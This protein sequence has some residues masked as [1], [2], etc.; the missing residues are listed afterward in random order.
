MSLALIQESAKEVRRLAI[1]GSPLAIGDFRLKKLVAPLEQAGAK[2]P[3]FAQV[4]RSIR[5]LIE[6]K[7]ADSAA[8]LLSL[9]TLLNA[10]LY[11]QGQTGTPAA[12]EELQTHAPST[13][14]NSVSTRTS[15]RVLRPIIEALTS[16]GSG[17]FEVVRTAVERGAFTD[18]RLIEPAL[19]ALGDVY[20]ELADLVAEKILPGYGAGIGA[21]VKQNFQIKGKKSDARRLLVLH[22]I[23]RPAGLALA[24]TALEEGSAE[25][26]E[27]AIACLG[28]HEDCLPLVLEQATTSKNKTLRAAALAALADYDRPETTK[29]FTE[30]V[31]GKTLELL[32]QP[33]RRIRNP[34]VLAAL[35]TEGR[36]VLDLLLKG[37]ETQIQRFC[38]VLDCL[39]QRREPACEEFVLQCFASSD[40]IS[41]LKP[42]KN[43]HVSGADISIRLVGLL[44]QLRTAKT[45]EALLA[46]RESIPAAAFYLVLR[47]AL[48]AWPPTKVFEEFSPLLAAAAKKGALAEKA[49][50]LQRTLWAAHQ[51]EGPG[52]FY[53]LEPLDSE[54]AAELKSIRWDPRWLDAAIKADDFE[55]AC[56]LARPG[57]A[58]A[59]QYFLKSLDAKKP[60]EPAPVIEALASCQY[61]KIT[62]VFL[63]LVKKKAKSKSQYVEYEISQLLQSARYLPVADLP[64]LDA[65]AATLE[66]KFVDSFLEALGPLRTPGQPAEE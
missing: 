37:D 21:L 6:G 62:D 11:T 29:L 36:R 13:P 45:R 24:K 42:A 7:E 2:V 34:D 9:S 1:A 4:A 48:L 32:A 54:A 3:V 12:L 56:T 28:Q 51:R 39:E 44:Y 63:D 49:Q 35:L 41:K 64:K 22:R 59:V 57:H 10:I 55:S 17:R 26:K 47:T 25:V 52:Y 46:K 40:K 20:P 27:A 16:T 50:Q 31:G 33:F 43:S 38:E 61:A 60:A 58:N 18:L 14:T 5:D 19:Q 15:A 65:F 66:E 23:D 30:L 8:N 53:G